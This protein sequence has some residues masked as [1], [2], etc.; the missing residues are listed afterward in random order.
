MYPFELN[1][2]SCRIALLECG[3]D[4]LDDGIFLVH[5]EPTSPFLEELVWMLYKRKIR[6]ATGPK[7]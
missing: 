7:L 3:F 2:S 6:D 1:N 4:L 5:I